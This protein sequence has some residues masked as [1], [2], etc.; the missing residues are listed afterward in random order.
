MR[1]TQAMLH[2]AGV[3]VL[4]GQYLTEVK[5]DGA[6]ITLLVTKSGTYS[7][8]VFV[9]GSYEGDLMAAAGVDWTIGREGRAEFNESYA[10]KQYPKQ[11]PIMKI[12]GFDDAGKLLPLVTIAEIGPDD[13]F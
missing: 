8:K 6:R 7:A 11:K 12:N 5:K 4:T 2:E 1:V 10:G 3:K 13:L 9:D